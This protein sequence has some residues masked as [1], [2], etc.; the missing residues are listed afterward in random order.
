MRTLLLERAA[1]MLRARDPV[2]LRSLVA[3]TGVSTMAVYTWF[4]GMDGLWRALRQEG[5]TRLAARMSTVEATV[6]SVADLAALAAAYVRNAVDQPD[7]YRVMFDATIEL[8]DLPAAD[9][10]LEK[11]VHGVARCQDE[12]RLEGAITSLDAATQSWAIT[13]GVVSLAVDGPLSAD[14]LRHLGPLLVALYVSLG[15]EPDRCRRSVEIGCGR[16]NDEQH[17]RPP[18]VADHGLEHGGGGGG[19]HQADSGQ[20]AALPS[21]RPLADPL[22]GAEGEASVQLIGDGR[23]DSAGQF[24]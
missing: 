6:D 13:H 11:L 21:R 8:A 14:T 4:G 19:G 10:C 18:G 9:A 5:F 20:R 1:K 15:D 22:V 24:D 7:L 23:D 12:G 16:R 2:T 17:L 3:G